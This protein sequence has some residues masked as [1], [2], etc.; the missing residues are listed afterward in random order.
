[1]TATGCVKNWS[2]LMAVRWFLGLAEAGIYP[3]VNYLLSCWYKRSEFGV[4]AVGYPILSLSQ[5]A[6]MS[7]PSSSPLPQSRVPLEVSSQLQLTSWTVEAA[8]LAGP[9]FSSSKE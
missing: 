5:K 4:R 3:G 9:G 2:G 6:D 1:M 7:R 8:D